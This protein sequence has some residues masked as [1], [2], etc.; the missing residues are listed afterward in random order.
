MRD[1]WWF[2]A[3]IVGPILLFVIVNSCMRAGGYHLQWSAANMRWV[4]VDA[5]GKP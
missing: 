2:V 3:I 5:N 1:K 4:Y